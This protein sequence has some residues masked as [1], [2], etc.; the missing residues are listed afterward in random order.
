MANEDEIL[1]LRCRSGLRLTAL[2]MTAQ[3]ALLK[4]RG[5]KGEEEI[6]RCAQDDSTMPLA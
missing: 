5:A 1:P 3:G 6:L 4:R 2:R